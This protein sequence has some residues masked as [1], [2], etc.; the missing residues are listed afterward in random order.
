[1]RR[2]GWGGD[3]RGGFASAVVSLGIL[4]PLGLLAFAPIGAEA[5]AV[6]VRAAFLGAILGGLVATAVGGAEVPG[7]GPKT[8]IAL[9]FAGFIAT[10]VADPA[11]RGPDG[12][13]LDA[14]L[15]LGALCVAAAGLLQIL[16]A[17]AR[18]GSA[19]SFVP[20][21]VV[22]GF[23]DGIAVLIAI[24][25]IQTLLGIATSGAAAGTASTVTGWHTGALAVG[26]AT[27]ALCWGLARRWPRAPWG[28]VG[29]VAGTALYGV[30]MRL[31]P[32][33]AFGGLLGTPAEGLDVPLATL[34]T[35]LVRYEAPLRAHAAALLTTAAV[36]A[37]IGALD[38]LLSAM[39]VDTRLNT[40][41]QSN[42][43]LLG[44]G[45]AN[46]VSGL[47]GGLPV[48]T[49]SA[50]QLAAAGAGGR[51]R[52]VGVACALVLLAILVVV[53]PVLGHVPVAATA[54][55][56]LV[57]A[58]GL[59][60]QW[61]GALRRQ[62]RAGSRDR[63]AV[64]NIAIAGIV[65]V[66]TI[67]FGFVVAIVVGFGLAAV[68]FVNEMNRSLVR[69]VGSGTTRGS[70][71][72]YAPEE[73]AVL[74]EHGDGIRIVE[75]EGAIFFGTAHRCERDLTRLARG[76]RFL[77]LDIRRVTMI[78][79]SGVFVLERLATRLQAADAR[80]VLAGIV[81][82]DRHA[83]ALRTNGVRLLREEAWHADSDRALEEAERATLARLGAARTAQELP[84]AALSLLEGMDDA[85][86]AAMLRYLTRVE[87]AAGEILFRRGEPGDRLYVLAKGSVS[88]LADLTH[89]V[90]AAHR[91]ASFAPGVIFGE[92]AMLDAGGRTAGA[93][94]DEPSVVYVLTRADLDRIRAEEPALAILVLLNVA[95]QLSARLRFATATIQAAER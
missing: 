4:L 56:M 49:S 76:A 68:L 21:P 62:L 32:D 44:L 13:M 87:L 41:H 25:Q 20:R 89:G 22:A 15:M 58:L 57:V 42:R 94:A 17:V 29:I 2:D 34:A 40:R 24:S 60:D 28:V 83:R 55:V 81:P 82:G 38:A 1:M 46:A 75:L 52:R 66:I 78:D 31:F 7:T 48:A 92:T 72:I 18:M 80:V 77:I 45:L 59:L 51:G 54:G 35:D 86:R 53:G 69:S 39:A 3:L 64:W 90:A 6:G 47:C 65:C 93:A 23:M 91:L 50:V 79:A 67:V 61:S 19:V 11:L 5:G 10:L 12:L 33:G 8:S 9:I 26:L 43:L 14:I 16:F 95:R 71:R 85:Q 27:A 88:I 30:A 37:I 74:R 36:I 73:A 63:D 70:R 84:P